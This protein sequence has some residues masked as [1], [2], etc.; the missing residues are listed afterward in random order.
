MVVSLQFY[1]QPTDGELLG[2]GVK[3]RN[4]ARYME[5][6]SIIFKLIIYYNWLVGKFIY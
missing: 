4:E 6:V 5:K 2:D 1:F 3:S